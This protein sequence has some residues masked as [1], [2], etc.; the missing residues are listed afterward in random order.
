MIDLY[1]FPTPNTWKI[2][3]MLEE[4][5]LDYRILPIDIMNGD[6]QKPEFLAVS[7]NGRVPAIV[8]QESGQQVFES[9]A[10][11][12]YLAEKTGQF[13]APSGPARIAAME[14]LFW[15]VGGLGPMAGQAHV[16]RRYHPDNTLGVERYTQEC[17]RLYGVLDRQ[18]DGQDWLAGAYSIADMAS[19]GWVWFGPMHG[20]ALDAFPNVKRW[21]FRMAERPAVQRAKKVGLEIA[22]PEFRAVL[23]ANFYQEEDTFAADK[24]DA[25]YA[26][27]N[28]DAAK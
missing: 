11:L 26:S 10:I 7:P 14:W 3:I 13:L 28:Q 9:G 5:A 21:F 16:F 15:Q 24:T 6:Q 17:A 19:W 25:V 2:A 4:C 23:E 22:P 8:D 18:L 1:Y 12:M 20:Q 27:K